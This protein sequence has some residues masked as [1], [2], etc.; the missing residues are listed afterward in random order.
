LDEQI[1]KTIRTPTEK[2]LGGKGTTN[3]AGAATAAGGATSNRAETIRFNKD[4][5]NP[6]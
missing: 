4:L 3:T 2:P 5:L 6:T 1:G